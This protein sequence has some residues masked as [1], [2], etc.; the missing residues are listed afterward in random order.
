M[1]TVSVSDQKST[2]YLDSSHAFEDFD[3]GLNFSF[4]SSLMLTLVQNSNC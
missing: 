1:L 4:G 3:C 2:A